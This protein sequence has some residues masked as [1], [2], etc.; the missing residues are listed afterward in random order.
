[1][2]DKHETV[3]AIDKSNVKPDVIYTIRFLNE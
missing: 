3:D 2:S 1:M